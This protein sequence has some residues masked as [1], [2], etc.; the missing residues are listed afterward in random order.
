MP[1]IKY[2]ESAPVEKTVV[3][4][5]RIYADASKVWKIA[6]V[7]LD[8]CLHKTIGGLYSEYP[9]Q[10]AVSINNAFLMADKILKIG[11]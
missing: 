2:T 8:G 4:D 10:A 7:L 1:V 6:N 11:D 3:V 9:I 5:D